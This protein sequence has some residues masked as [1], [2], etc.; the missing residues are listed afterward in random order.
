MKLIPIR[1]VFAHGEELDIR[2]VER[3]ARPVSEFS[4]TVITLKSG[5]EIMS[6]CVSVW[7]EKVE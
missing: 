2:T 7:W 4:A 1:I 3:V 6:Q 5:V